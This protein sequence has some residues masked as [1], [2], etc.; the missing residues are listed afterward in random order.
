MTRK[1]PGGTWRR[2][3]FR[4]QVAEESA[5]EMEKDEPE[6]GPLGWEA[7]DANTGEDG[8]RGRRSLFGRGNC[9]SKVDTLILRRGTVT[10]A[11]A[12]VRKGL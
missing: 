5:E 1:K 3:V 8:V 6:V 7:G 2:L 10:C 11:F 9:K 4:A 12:E